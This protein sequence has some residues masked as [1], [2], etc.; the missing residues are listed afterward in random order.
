MVNPFDQR[1]KDIWNSISEERRLAASRVAA[2]HVHIAVKEEQAV[3][4][5]KACDKTLIDCLIKI[6]DHSD[7]KRTTAYKIMSQSNGIPPVFSSTEQLLSYIQKHDG[8]RNVWDL[9]RYKPSTGTIEF[10]MF[11]ATEDIEEIAYYVEVCLDL[12]R[13]SI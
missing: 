8:E 1:H 6:G 3:R 13:S 4:V 2:T 9:V 5:L 10:R 12:Y 7:G 11:G